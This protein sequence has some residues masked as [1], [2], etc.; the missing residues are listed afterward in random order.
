MQ[1]KTLADLRQ[2]FGWALERD[3]LLAEPCEK[4]LLSFRVNSKPRK[5]R[6]SNGL[7]ILARTNGPNTHTGT[8]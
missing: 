2:M 6:S 8:R 4:P 3:Y 7:C 1:K 5:C